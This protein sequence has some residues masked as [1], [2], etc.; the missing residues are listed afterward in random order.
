[1]ISSGCA[2]GRAVKAV[3]L[4]VGYQGLIHLCY[5]LEHEKSRGIEQIRSEWQSFLPINL[6]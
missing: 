1:M 5:S 4:P 6:W 2:A 3:K